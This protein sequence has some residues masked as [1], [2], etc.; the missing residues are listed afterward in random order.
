MV[1]HLSD[2]DTEKQNNSDQEL[3]LVICELY[4]IFLSCIVIFYNLFW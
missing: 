4:P 1:A 2:I 3:S